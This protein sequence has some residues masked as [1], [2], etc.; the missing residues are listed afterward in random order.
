MLGKKQSDFQKEQVRKALLGKS[1][2]LD[3]RNNMSN[4]KAGKFLFINPVTG[5]GKYISENEIE[6]YTKLGWYRK[7]KQ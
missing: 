2:S 5:K 3:T 6:Q 7:K 1:K 4:G